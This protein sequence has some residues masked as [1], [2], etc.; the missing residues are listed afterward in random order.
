[1]RAKLVLAIDLGEVGGNNYNQI[2]YK[3]EEI[4]RQLPLKS[5]TEF[6]FE[7]DGEPVKVRVDVKMEEAMESSDHLEI[8]LDGDK[9]MLQHLPS[10]LS[11]GFQDE[12]ELMEHLQKQGITVDSLE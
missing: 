7:I 5:L 4:L 3:V 11:S 2:E 8:T 12:Q 1:M 6:E 9:E 10:K